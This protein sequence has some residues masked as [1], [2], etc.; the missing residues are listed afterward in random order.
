MAMKPAINQSTG[1]DDQFTQR[2]VEP[3]D[4]RFLYELYCSTR[5]EEIAQWG[6]G[7]EQRELFLQMQFR[8]Q[9]QHFSRLAGSGVDRLIL[10]SDCPIGRLLVWRGEHEIRLVDIALLPAY[11]NQGIGK[12]LLLKLQEEAAAAHLPLTLHVLEGSRA[13]HLYERLGFALVS[14]EGP[15]WLMSWV[16]KIRE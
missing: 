5:A 7:A 2:P 6:W 12:T 16:P 9:S 14:Q 15:Y 3:E 1:T 8:A 13:V 10:R 11:R 4:E